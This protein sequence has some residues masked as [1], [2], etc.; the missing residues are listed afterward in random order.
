MSKLKDVLNEAKKK[1]SKM[2]P[3]LHALDD[4]IEKFIQKLEDKINKIKDNPIFVKKAFQLLGDMSKEYSEFMF[5][6]RAVVN[7]VDR[8]GMVLPQEKPVGKVRDINS[9]FRAGD[10]NQTPPEEEGEE[11]PPE[12]GEEAPPK[13]KGI[14]EALESIGEAKR[15]DPYGKKLLGN[16]EDHKSTK[17][18]EYNL[19][20]YYDNDKTFQPWVVFVMGIGP[21]GHGDSRAEVLKKGK[22]YLKK[23]K[24]IDVEKWKKNMASYKKS[25]II[26]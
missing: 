20:T 16:V 8:K 1:D 19:E 2:L 25:G 26:K 10:E 5:A 14:K 24:P 18:G 6:L 3:E 22:D 7:A 15:T 17:V 21:V 9:R 23:M 11:A 4:T 12:E 13:K